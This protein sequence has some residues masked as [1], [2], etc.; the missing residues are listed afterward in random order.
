MSQ[1]GLTTFH[2]QSA[3]NDTRAGG[4]MSPP[5]HSAALSAQQEENVL[6]GSIYKSLNGLAFINVHFTFFFTCSTSGK[7]I[8]SDEN[9]K[10]TGYIRGYRNKYGFLMHNKYWY[11]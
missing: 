11:V 1:S 2:S 10:K 8:F 7:H 6:Y 3:N 9:G 4:Q 5:C